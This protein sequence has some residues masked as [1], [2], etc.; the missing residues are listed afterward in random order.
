M[1]RR[2]ATEPEFR[3]H[4]IELGRRLAAIRRRCLS[5]GLV[6]NRGGIGLHQRASGHTGYEEVQA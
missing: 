5:C 4:F 2:I 3:Q 6:S 1:A